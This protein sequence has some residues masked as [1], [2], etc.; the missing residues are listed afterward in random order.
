M[1]LP[2]LSAIW[3]SAA[4]PGPVDADLPPVTQPAPSSSLEITVYAQA[5][6]DPNTTQRKASPLI[7]PP[8]PSI[9]PSEAVAERAPAND[10]IR[11]Y[12]AQADGHGIKLGGINQSR[13]AEDWRIMR[14]PAKRDDPLDRLKYL[15]ID[16]NGDV[17]LTLSGEGRIR[18]NYFSNPGLVPSEH[19]REDRLRLV[20]GAD[21]H[22]GPFR[23]FG[24]LAHGGLGGHNYGKAP[25]NARNDLVAQQ[26][27]GEV[28]GAIGTAIAGI[29]YGR[30]EFTDGPPLLVTQ[31]DNNTIRAVLDGTRAWAQLSNTRLDLFDFRQVRFGL[32]GL[33]DDVSDDGTRFSGATV[34][35]VLANDATRKLFLDPFVWRERTD[36]RRWGSVTAREVRYYTGARMWGSI[37]R[38]TIDW[39]VDHQGGSFDGRD[40]DAWNFFIAQTYALPNRGPKLG[41]HVDYGSGGSGGLDGTG[42]IGA[43]RNMNGGAIPYSYQGALNIINLFQISPNLTISPLSGVNVTFEY[44]HSRRNDQEDAIY[45]GNATPYAGTQLV[46]GHHV[47]DGVKVQTGWS[48]TKR[49]SFTSRYE[50]FAPG[51]V[52]TQLGY[53]GSH[54]L[55]GWLSFRI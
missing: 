45:K 10:A 28:S 35:I 33:D 26:A 36:R 15:P 9:P 29:R 27:F 30:Q 11:P 48:I 12:P 20:A 43:A 47:G 42:E 54:Y 44:Q 17:Y 38:L 7:P 40:V 6:R 18:A 22:V 21:L 49:L 50:Y 4:A 24:E 53:D 25:T 3:L 5:N 55:A 23:L 39:T 41:I 31:K 16:A 8:L 2:A 1:S 13:W 51:E 32:N 37:D 34:G 14:D 46:R 52:L 19:R